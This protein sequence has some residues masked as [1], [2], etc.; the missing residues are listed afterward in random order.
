[1]LCSNQYAIRVL[2]PFLE[3]P[4]VL[5]DWLPWHH[6]F[7]G[8]HN[9]NLVLRNGGTLYIDRGR[10]VPG[11]FHK[12]LANLRDVPPTVL[13]NVPR[14]YDLLVSALR[15]DPALGAR[16]FANLKLLF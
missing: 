15:D 10:P 8:N 16:I 7:G 1:M 5:V 14:G 3:E 4:P 13:L 9:F 2:W 11:D 12:T 6:T